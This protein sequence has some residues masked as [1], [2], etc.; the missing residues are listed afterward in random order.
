MLIHR[1]NT[2]HTPLH[3][4]ALHPDTLPNVCTFSPPQ[5]DTEP[6]PEPDP[7]YAEYMCSVTCLLLRS[8]SLFFSFFFLFSL[9]SPCSFSSL[10]SITHPSH[11]SIHSIPIPFPFP[12]PPP[13]P[14]PPP[15]PLLFNPL[16][17]STAQQPLFV[18]IPSPHHPL[19]LPPWPSSSNILHH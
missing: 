1:H 14:T 8:H 19:V 9:S 6:E 17:C 12:Y 15:P 7:L 5:V 3:A 16:T 10:C 11:P 18:L 4:T 13:H 2:N